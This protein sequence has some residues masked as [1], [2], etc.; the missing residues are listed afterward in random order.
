MISS[1]NL[2]F[3]F[4]PQPSSGVVVCVYGHSKSSLGRVADEN[5]FSHRK[6]RLKVRRR[7][8]RKNCV[9]KIGDKFLMCGEVENE[10]DLITELRFLMKHN[11]C[12][13]VY[14]LNFIIY[15]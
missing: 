10:K 13:R 12:E 7:E 4:F 3:T 8:R 15:N 9:G 1:I 5:E 6:K 2:T 14:R 11:I